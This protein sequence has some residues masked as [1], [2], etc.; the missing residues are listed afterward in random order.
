VRPSI[1]FNPFIINIANPG[2]IIV[3]TKNEI[4]IIDE[5]LLSVKSTNMGFIQYNIT[6]NN[7]GINKG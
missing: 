3:D 7:N 2:K 6:M 1:R 4:T 5:L